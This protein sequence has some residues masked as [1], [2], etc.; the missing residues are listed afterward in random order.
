MVLVEYILY[1]CSGL[2]IGVVATMAGIGGGVFMVPLFYFLG[3]GISNAI[4]TS[5]FVISFLSFIGAINY[6][7]MRK[8]SI[9]TSIPVLIGMIPASYIGAYASN[10]LDRDLL[11]VVIPVFII[12]Y[13]LRLIH[14]YIDSRIK[15]TSGRNNI[16][17]T[18][19]MPSQL[20]IPFTKAIPIGLVS[21]FVAGLTGTG[22]GVVN[23]PFFLGVLGIPIHNAVALSTFVI[24]PSSIAATVRHILNGDIVY[25]IG[26]PF[27]LGAVIGASIG[28][29]IACRLSRNK[30][31]LF[32]GIVLLYAGTK[33]LI[34]VIT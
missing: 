10:T 12:F 13:S 29:I 27:T 15:R 32:V 21:G 23:M 17:E 25:V 11:R 3:L 8:V 31:R 26:I 14:K 22:G 5:K 7:R 33:M 9:S 19:T 18:N 16:V 24:F 2:L 30:L 34:S 20:V 4:G 6:L 1:I 28:P